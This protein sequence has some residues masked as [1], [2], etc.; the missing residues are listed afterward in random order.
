MTMPY[1]REDAEDTGLTALLA[2]QRAVKLPRDAMTAF[3]LPGDD[4]TVYLVQPAEAGQPPQLAKIT[5]YQGHEEVLFPEVE[6]HAEAAKRLQ[7]EVH[8]LR[9][10]LHAFARAMAMEKVN[11]GEMNKPQAVA[12]MRDAVEGV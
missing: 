8:A 7:G 10:H 4:D 11:R 2:L 5:G 3:Q 6:G 1:H 12:W 9:K